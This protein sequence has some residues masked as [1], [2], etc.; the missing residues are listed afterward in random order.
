[1]QRHFAAEIAVTAV[2]ALWSVRLVVRMNTL[3]AAD[4]AAG[5]TAAVT[6]APPSAATTHGTMFVTTEC[7]I[8]VE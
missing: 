1:M 7:Y 5:N 8:L 3:D 4:K 6:E 2:V